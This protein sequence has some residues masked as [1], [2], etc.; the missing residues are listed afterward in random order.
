MSRSSSLSLKY[1]PG[2]RIVLLSGLLVTLLLLGLKADSFYLD[3]RCDF[4]IPDFLADVFE[5][6]VTLDL[7]EAKL[8]LK[9]E[10]DDWFIC[11]VFPVLWRAERVLVSFICLLLKP[12]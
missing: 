2:L 3:L 8:F 12:S 9:P 1:L 5:A 7:L 6:E 4:I 10:V 11:E